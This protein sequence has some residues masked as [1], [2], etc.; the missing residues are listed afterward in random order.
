[1]RKERLAYMTLA[2]HIKYMRSKGIHRSISNGICVEILVYTVSY[3]STL[4]LPS[5]VKLKFVAV[6]HVIVF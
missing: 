3:H 2:E 6:K 5:S 4:V 1:M